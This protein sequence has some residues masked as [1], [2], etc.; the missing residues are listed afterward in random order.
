MSGLKPIQQDIYSIPSDL[1]SLEVSSSV[2]YMIFRA[3]DRVLSSI[4]NTTGDRDPR[5][6]LMTMFLINT[7]PD[8]KWRKNIIENFKNLRKE[9]GISDITSPAI[10]IWCTEI[11]GCVTD[12]QVKYRGAVK[13]VTVGRV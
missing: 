6:F 12:W 4:A 10:H 13:N 9:Y 2:D 3:M 1:P 11:V 8:V 5:P 7:I